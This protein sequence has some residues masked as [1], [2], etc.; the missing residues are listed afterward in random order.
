VLALLYD[1][2]GNLT[3]LEAV[4]AD[5]RARGADGW[6]LGGDLSLF[7]PEPEAT[8][9]LLR[10]LS[11]AGWLRGNGERWTADP[12]GAPDNAVVPA[13]IAACREALGDDAVAELGALPEQIVHERTRFVHGS[14]VSDVRSFMPEPED[15]EAELLDGVAEPRLVF[16]HT[17]LPFRRRSAFGGIELVNPGSV[18]LPFD[19]DRRAAYALVHVD[20]SV[21][22]RRVAYDHGAS[23]ARLRERWPGADWAETVARRI[24]QAR[25]DV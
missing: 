5:A 4:I 1:V 19:G 11:P 20:G 15:D 16:G 7:G 24:E 17:H 14:P 21:E 22:H 9:A 2:H 25:V 23:A 18:G 6:L 10:E 8:V 12:G 13:A 3:A